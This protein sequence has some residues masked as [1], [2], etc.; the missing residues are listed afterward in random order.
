MRASHKPSDV[1]IAVLI[2]LLM[3]D[4][5]FVILHI[6]HV[7]SLE[8]GG[9]SSSLFTDPRLSLGT[10]RGYAEWFGYGKLLFS[11]IVLF[12]LY[13]RVKG[14]AYLAWSFGLLVV[15]VDD[16]FMVHERLGREFAYRLALRPA[17]GLRA[18]DFGELAAWTT[19][20]V[21]LLTTLVLAHHRSV[22]EARRDSRVLFLLLLAL[23]FF[24]AVV[25]M[26][27]IPL[28]GWAE[29]V[30]EITEEGGELAVLSG[31]VAHVVGST[32]RHRHAVRAH[33]SE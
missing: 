31:I 16:S 29:R 19:L 14:P 21:P 17:F 6:I 9:D 13:R 27:H 12:L 15:L 33:E 11:A 2:V 26:V 4:A 5:V 10:D 30:A 32:L 25:D 8:Y 7:L 28:T 24:G 23:V 18:Q 20:A 3:V 22:P 1:A